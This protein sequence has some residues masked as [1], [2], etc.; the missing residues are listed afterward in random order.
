MFPRK[1][2]SEKW[3]QDEH[4]RSFI[5]WLRKCV[6]ATPEGVAERVKWLARGRHN[7]VMK[8]S[9]Y[10]INGVT[11][12]TRARN[13]IRAVQNSGVTLVAKTMQV[14]SAKDMNPIMSDMTYYG[15]IDKIWELDY[16]NFRVSR[17]MKSN[18]EQNLDGSTDLDQESKGSKSSRSNKGRVNLDILS[19]QRAKRI[20]K[21]VNF[22]E[23]RQPIGPAATEMQSYIGVLTHEKW[24]KGCLASANAKWRQWKTNLYNK[25]IVPFE[26]RP[27]MLYNPPP[28]SGILREDWKDFVISSMSEGFR[29]VS[30]EQK[31]QRWKNIYPHHLSRRGYAGLRE[32]MKSQL[33]GDEELDRAMLW[34]QTRKNKK[35]EFD[36]EELDEYARQKKEGVFSSTHPK[37]DILTQSLETSEHS[38][39]VRAVGAH[40][41]PTTYFNLAKS[42]ARNV[43]DTQLMEMGKK[44]AEMDAKI[45]ELQTLMGSQM[46]KDTDEKESC[47]VKNQDV[48]YFDDVEDIAHENDGQ[49]VKGYKIVQCEYRK[50]RKEKCYLGGDQEH[51][52]NSAEDGYLESSSAR[53]VEGGSFASNSSRIMEKLPSR[54]GGNSNGGNYVMWKSRMKIYIKSID[55]RAWM[56]VIEEW[57]PP[58][59]EG[60]NGDFVLTSES[61]W[62]NDERII[63][64]FNARAL[65]E[66]FVSIDV[67][68]FKMICNCV[69][70]YQAWTILQEHCEGFANV[71]KTK[72]RLL[73]SKFENLRMFEDETIS[74][75]AE[76]LCEMSN[77]STALGSPISNENMVSKLLRTLPERFNMKISAIEEAHDVG[78]MSM[79]EAVSILLTFEMNLQ[80]QK[81]NSTS[82]GT[83]LQTTTVS[84]DVHDDVDSLQEINEEENLSV[85][86]LTKKFN[87]LVRS[88]RKAPQTSNLDGCLTLHPHQHQILEDQM[89]RRKLLTLGKTLI[90]FNVEHALGMDIIQMNV[91]QHEEDKEIILMLFSVMSLILKMS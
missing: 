46:K 74:S 36:S 1:L 23:R 32:E 9:T 58:R 25:F 28:C 13:S 83:A 60:P 63:S 34:K 81:A 70:A 65:N 12:H 56:A 37:Q 30:E 3:L 38:G 39:R 84:S 26:N 69:T 22:N 73:T 61:Q 90:Q 19:I 17:T 75:Y 54:D 6:I 79:S 44:M 33:S 68:C 45:L 57:S 21:D 80:N 76:K 86:L 55:E 7:R 49:N 15:V 8:Y 29:K 67:P 72:L 66:I 10:M 18:S 62:T 42:V 77:Q 59:M 88:M 85:A 24:K 82:K 5:A 78:T 31:D 50:T 43:Q 27:E 2:R 52:P 40:V 48:Q 16:N 41:T 91:Q 20:T 47:S 35:S 53:V 89:S 87:S 14:S 51:V 71:R 11:Y 64:N 4:N